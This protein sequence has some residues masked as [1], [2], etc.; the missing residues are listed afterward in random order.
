[1]KKFITLFIVLLSTASM[2]Q[3]Y[4]AF[5]SRST[6]VRAVIYFPEIKMEKYPL[7]ITQHGSRP[8]EKIGKCNLFG[9]GSECAKTDVFSMTVIKQGL[10][11]GFAV[12]AID[13]FT[14]LGIDANNKTTYPNAYFFAAD[15]RQRL[16]SD[17]RIDS[18]N[19]FYTGWSYGGLA[20]MN[21]MRYPRLDQ[22]RAT[23]P[24]ETT[25]HYQPG[26]RKLYYPTLYVFG[27]KSHFNPKPCVWLLDKLKDNGSQVEMIIVPNANHNF[28]S[29]ESRG[30]PARS[31][32]GCADNH[33][34]TEDSGWRRADGSTIDRQT[35]DKECFTSVGYGSNDFAKMDEAVSHVIKFFSKVQ[36]RQ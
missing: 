20:V 2:A 5:Q 21:S 34:I 16:Q 19:I 6:N 25:C 29:G 14:D 31:L 33:V 24:V 28:G 32:N 8:T 27:E 12:V 36:F 13:A 3:E 30:G 7:I 18:T 35:A 10:K 17:S 22:W 9:Q 4:I 26:A 15:L 11:A 23:A 1:M